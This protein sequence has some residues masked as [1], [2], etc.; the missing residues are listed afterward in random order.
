MNSFKDSCNAVSG[1]NSTAEDSSVSGGCSTQAAD[2]THVNPRNALWPTYAPPMEIVFSHGRGSELF[3][4]DGTVYLDFISG[5]AVTGFGHA[6]PRLVNALHDQSKHLWHLSNLFRV[7]EAERLAKRLVDNC[8]GDRVFFTNSGAESCEAG[9]KAIRGYHAFKGNAERYRIISMSGAFHGRTLGAISAAG[10]PSHT[11]GFIPFDYGFDQ[12][13]WG[14]LP[15]L[16][17]AISEETA[18][19]VLEPVQG[20]GGVRPVSEA[21]MHGVRNLCDHHGILLMFDEVQCGMGRTGKMFAH[22]HYDVTP[23]VMA[24]A[25]GIGGGFPLGA[26]VATE[27]VASAMGIGTHGSTYGGNPLAAA[28]ANTIMDLLLEED[29]LSEVQRKGELLQKLLQGLV[30]KFPNQLKAVSGK[31][32]MIGVECV[33]PNTDLLK[34]L[35]D[36]HL[37]VG[38]AGGNMLR[39]LPPLNVSDEHLQQACD[40][41]ES[42]LEANGEALAKATSAQ[43]V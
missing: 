42:V 25:K 33:I 6:H 20:E 38:K 4:T 9:L 22:Q 19:I 5:I 1:P 12:V 32:L 37:L 8:F 3:T 27:A 43:I 15:A 16:E 31:G 11:K 14:D 21:F 24:L 29:C 36:H 18:G 41:F 17:A 23:D 10:N 13:P 28:V 30:R 26:C 34:L 2:E 40:I 35:R 39:F 7:P